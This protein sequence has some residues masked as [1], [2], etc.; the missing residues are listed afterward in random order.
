MSMKFACMVYNDGSKLAHLPEADQLKAI[1]AECKAAVLWRRELEESGRHVFSAG[2]QVPSTA[3]TLRNNSGKVFQSDGPF[4]ETKEF[5]GGFTI[6]EARDRNE[7]LEIASRLASPLMTIELR[8]VLD[9]NADVSDPF[10]QKIADTLQASGKS[11]R[12]SDL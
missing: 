3:T 8:P 10:Q 12:G 11:A 2:L 7:A 9:A 4:A 5:L 1:M 6:F